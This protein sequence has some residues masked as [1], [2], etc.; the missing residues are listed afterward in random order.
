MRR[1]REEKDTGLGLTRANNSDKLSVKGL[2]RA[3]LYI[4]SPV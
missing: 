3:R 4:R 1:E 2:A